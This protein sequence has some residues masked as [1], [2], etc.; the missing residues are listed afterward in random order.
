MI[1][2]KIQIHTNRISADLIQYLTAMFQYYKKRDV[3][4]NYDISPANISGYKSTL[5]VVPIVGSVYTL[6]GAENLVPKNDHDITMFVYDLNE[7]KAPWYWPYPL[8]NFGPMG[9]LPRDCTYMA[10]G[11]PFIS[12]GFYL[13]DIANV[14][15]RLKHEPMHA[16]AK[17]F[18]CQDVMDTYDQDSNPDSPTGNFAKQFAIFQ[19]YINQ[20]KKMNTATLKRG[21][22]DSKETLGTQI[23]HRNGQ[24][25]TVSTVELPWLNNQQNVSCIPIGTYLCKWTPFHDTHH[26]ELQNVP[27]RTG[28]FMHN[29]N[30]YSD[31]LG[32]IIV[33]TIPA[34]I[35]HDGEL[36]VTSSV[37]T[38]AAMEA[39]MNK[40]DFTLT[41]E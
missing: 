37:V 28:I 20:S 18:G 36:D 3:I 29:G 39:F 9:N 30:Y 32:C 38:L 31:S 16:L 35:N 10:N 4:L 15:Q 19:P 22:G 8:W 40:E 5:T 2:K 11:K 24:S 23:L 14:Q 17:I 33:G 25:M 7:W 34:D 27:G 12:L 21:K 41:I 26:Y 6:Q 13:P 1:T